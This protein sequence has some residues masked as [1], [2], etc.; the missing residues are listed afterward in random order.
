MDQN[1]SKAYSFFS[2]NFF[3][4]HDLE[5]VHSFQYWEYSI[6]L[7]FHDF[8]E[9]AIVLEGEGTHLLED[10]ECIARRGCVFAIPPGVRH[11]YV[12]ENGLRLH[13]ILLLPSFFTHYAEEMN[14]MKGALLLFEIAPQLRLAQRA[15]VLYTLDE[16][17]TKRLEIALEQCE[18]ARISHYGGRE[19]LKNAAVLHLIGTL[20]EM[21]SPNGSPENTPIEILLAMEYIDRHCSED[22]TVER[23]C[24]R[25]HLS[26]TLF[27]RKFCAIANR[28]PGE[29]LLD[30]RLR[31]ARQL[32]LNT[33]H[34]ITD[35]AMQCG[36]YDS[37]HFIRKFAAACGVTPGQFRTGATQKG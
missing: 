37:S 3:A 13:N 20:C 21:L 11:A 35:I 16:A 2:K 26:R 36:F 24:R 18:M 12:T 10:S 33:R 17:Q 28:T 32:L 29:Y 25:F 23:L 19:V 7:H 5:Y 30:C 27:Y 14:T 15:T 9:L 4:G 31:R 8:Y 22:I 1:V 34:S 6:D